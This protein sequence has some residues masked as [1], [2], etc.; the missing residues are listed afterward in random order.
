MVAADVRHRRRYDATGQHSRPNAAWRQRMPGEVYARV[1]TKRMME[2]EYAGTPEPGLQCEG[3][4][5]A[6]TQRASERGDCAYLLRGGC[7][8]VAYVY[9]GAEVVLSRGWAGRCQLVESSV[10]G[11]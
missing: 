4:G 10:V 8:V 9:A 1:R 7:L 6:G 2:R 3:A 11:A 5:R